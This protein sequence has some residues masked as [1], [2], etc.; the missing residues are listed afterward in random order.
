MTLHN[1]PRAS[2]TSLK[3]ALRL[4]PTFTGDSLCACDWFPTVFQNKSWQ[5]VCIRWR[6]G[7]SAASL[8]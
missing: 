7:S 8:T 4:F 5:V 3:H 6:G 2:K 1:H